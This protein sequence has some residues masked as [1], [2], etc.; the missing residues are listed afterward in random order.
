MPPPHLVVNGD[1]ANARGG[2]EQWN[3]LGIE[4]VFERIGPSPA[5]WLHLL[6]WKA[7]IVLDPIR[8]RR[9]YQRFRVRAGIVGRKENVSH[10]PTQRTNYP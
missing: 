4:D 8:R 10:G 9:D 7:R 6:R 1:G 3:D 5:A 2:F